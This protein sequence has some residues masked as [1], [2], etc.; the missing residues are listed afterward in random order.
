MASTRAKIFSK[1]TKALLEKCVI[2]KY[3]SIFF[4]AD[5]SIFCLTDDGFS[6]LQVKTLENTFNLLASRF[7]AVYFAD[8]Q[9]MEREDTLSCFEHLIV[10]SF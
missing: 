6:N 10:K 3:D 4:P 7:F 9:F 5:D 2:N 8:K 1:E